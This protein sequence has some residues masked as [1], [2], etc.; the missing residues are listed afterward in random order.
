M[1]LIKMHFKHWNTKKENV[2]FGEGMGK[3]KWWKCEK[4]RILPKQ[5]KP[6]KWNPS[7]YACTKKNEWE[8]KLK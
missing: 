7:T 2:K 6:L 8:T 5:V 1:H 3:G 4:Q